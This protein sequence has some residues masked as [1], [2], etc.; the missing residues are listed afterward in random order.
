MSKF[1]DKLKNVSKGYV[2]PMGFNA[3]ASV[4]QPKMLLA[5]ELGLEDL[6]DKEAFGGADVVIVSVG[7]ASAKKLKETA[8]M[9]GDTIWGVALGDKAADAEKMAKAGADFVVFSP[10]AEVSPLTALEKTGKIIMLEN[11]LT[12]FMIRAAD[13]LSVGAVIVDNQPDALAL[14][15]R[16]IMLYQRFADILSKPFLVRVSSNITLSEL[17]SLW[18][19]G[20]DGVLIS[21]STGLKELRTLIDGAEWAV[22]RKR[23]HMSAIVPSLKMPASESVAP[24]EPEEPDEDD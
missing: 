3:V 22:K 14:S 23:G 2:R 17:Q 8:D 24:E 13:C 4:P 19:L 10:D 11:N 7:K 18:A 16:K 15:W 9:L 6:T 12:D 20:I 5:A 1:I 21:G